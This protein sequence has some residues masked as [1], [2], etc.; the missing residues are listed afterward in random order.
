M[1]LLEWEDGEIVKSWRNERRR[2]ERLDRLASISFLF[3]L[4]S[5]KIRCQRGHLSKFSS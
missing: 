4:S 1:M 3:R 2:R 5:S